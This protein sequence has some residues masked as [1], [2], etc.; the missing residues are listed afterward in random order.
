MRKQ[1]QKK[2]EGVER[3]FR[4]RQRVIAYSWTFLS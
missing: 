2:N 4:N 1:E 3:P